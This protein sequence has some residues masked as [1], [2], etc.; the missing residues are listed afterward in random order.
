VISNFIVQALK[1]DPITVYGDGSQTRSFCYVD[2][3]IEGL[4]KF[5]NAPRGLTG[6]INLGNPSEFTIGELPK[7]I[8]EMTWSRSRIEYKPLPQD[9]PLQR[10]PDI[11]LA[12]NELG[13]EPKVDLASGLIKTI[14]Y[15]ERLLTLRGEL[16]KG[17]PA[18][19]LFRTS[20][21]AE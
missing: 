12:K 3:L 17:A 13:W 8:I 5:M 21:S 20:A 7:H 18:L 14:S 15:F 16:E 6:P 19:G 1:G 11:G 2:D 9:D 4:I 10:Q